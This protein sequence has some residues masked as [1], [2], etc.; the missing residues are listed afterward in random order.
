MRV[1]K[2]GPVGQGFSKNVR[3]A[4]PCGGLSFGH[5][6]EEF[7]SSYFNELRY[8]DSTAFEVQLLRAAGGRCTQVSTEKQGISGT[9]NCV[10][11]SRLQSLTQRIRSPPLKSLMVPITNSGSSRK[12]VTA[13]FPCRAE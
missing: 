1:I 11:D 12:H 7:I 10:Q 9:P 13:Y 2:K 3:A 5:I 4:S 6:I 8:A